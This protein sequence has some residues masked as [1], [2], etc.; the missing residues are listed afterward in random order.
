G[1]A[2]LKAQPTPMFGAVSGGRGAAAEAVGAL[3]DAVTS[4]VEIPEVQSSGDAGDLAE[5]EVPAT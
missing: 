5:G 2:V 3:D 1:A 4:P